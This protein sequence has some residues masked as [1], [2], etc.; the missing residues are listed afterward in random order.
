MATA[1]RPL[2][3]DAVSEFAVIDVETMDAREED[4]LAAQEEVRREFEADWQPPENYKDPVKIAALREEKLAK[5]VDRIREQAALL[6]AAPVAMLGLMLEQQTFLLHGLKREKAK[7]FGKNGKA[8]HVSIEGFAGE[9]ELMEAA[10][11]ILERKTSAETLITGHNIFGFDLRKLRLATVRNGLTLPP[12]FRV[13]L[14]DGEERQSVLDTMHHFC[15][16]F[17][18]NGE[19]MISQDAMLERLGIGSLLKGVASGKDVPG[20]LAAGKV[21]EVATKLLA[22][23]MGVRQAVLRMTGRG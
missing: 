5:R 4:I 7:W 17:G 19:I 20:L 18:R 8:N 22:D 6:D 13:R 16:Y 1:I 15:K 12:A 3:A 21:T 23:L 11:E 2:A 9:K 14:V 10:A